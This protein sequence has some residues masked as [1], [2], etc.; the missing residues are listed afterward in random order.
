MSHHQKRNKEIKEF[1][2]V[3][4]IY[5]FFMIIEIIRGYIDRSI[6]IMSDAAHLLSDL[7]G[8]VISIIGL[9]ISKKA[10]N[11]KM[12][13]GYHKAEIIGVLSS[14]ILIWVLTLWLLYEATMRMIHPKHVKGK[15]MIIIDVIGFMFKVVVGLVFCCD[16]NLT[17]HH[18]HSHEQL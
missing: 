17:S 4:L 7:L 15:I 9:T 11:K 3:S 18:F 12:S 8:F 16:G 13:Y 10:A 14:V 2:F 5:L 1:I 6:A